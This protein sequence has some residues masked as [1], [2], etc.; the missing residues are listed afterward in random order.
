MKYLIKLTTS[1]G[2]SYN[3]QISG[4]IEVE[5]YIILVMKAELCPRSSI[6]NIEIK[7]SL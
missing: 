2:I 7:R 5:K 6:I 4:D 1:Q 3:Y